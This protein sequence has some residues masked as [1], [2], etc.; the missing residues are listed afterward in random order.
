ML[1]GRSSEIQKQQIWKKYKSWDVLVPLVQA[2][3]VVSTTQRRRN[4]SPP[5]SPIHGHQKSLMQ[6]AP[7][8]GPPRPGGQKCRPAYTSVIHHST[9]TKKPKPTPQRNAPHYRKE[10]PN[11]RKMTCT[12]LQYAAQAI[13]K[14]QSLK[15]P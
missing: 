11:P 12:P 15:N 13:Q 6:K 2:K 3:T 4:P 8:P 1:G 14:T 10:P 5:P 7:N 9:H